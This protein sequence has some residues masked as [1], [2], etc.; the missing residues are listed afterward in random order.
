MAYSCASCL[1]AAVA[2]QSMARMSRTPQYLCADSSLLRDMILCSLLE[3]KLLGSTTQVNCR[4]VGL[5]LQADL[6]PNHTVQ[7]SSFRG[8]T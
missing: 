6:P 8:D 4:Q 1:L 2:S 5:L 7:A 3:H